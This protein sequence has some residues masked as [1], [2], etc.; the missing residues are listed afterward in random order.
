MNDSYLVTNRNLQV[1]LIL[2]I[3]IN[4]ITNCDKILN[5]QLTELQKEQR[6]C[7]IH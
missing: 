3:L 5:F 2:L 6:L 7:K 4:H 1:F